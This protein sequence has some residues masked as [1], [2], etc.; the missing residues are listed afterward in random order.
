MDRQ[1][2]ARVLFWFA[3]QQSNEASRTVSYRMPR[4]P[5]RRLVGSPGFL[6]VVLQQR[7]E[8]RVALL[9]NL[10]I[11]INWPS[12][13]RHVWSHQRYAIFL[14]EKYYSVCSFW[15]SSH[16]W[17][18]VVQ[19]VF[20]PRDW[21]ENFRMSKETFL[22]LCSRPIFYRMLIGENCMHFLAGV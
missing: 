15:R 5:R 18:F 1:R 13:E 9:V 12:P 21:K 8:T 2:A 6:R 22:Y 17:E 16:W 7:R 14:S 10:L 11:L 19:H 4:R 3:L 20:S